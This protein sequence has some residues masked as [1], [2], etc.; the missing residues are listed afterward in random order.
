VSADAVLA[1]GKGASDILVH[2]KAH[3]D[4]SIA[5]DSI[6]GA[7]QILME[8][9][10]YSKVRRQ[11][12]REIGSFQAIKHRCADMK[13]WLEAAKALTNAAI[14]RFVAGEY[15][16]PLI[17]SAKVYASQTYREIAMD[18]VQIHGGIG[19]TWEHDCHLFLKRALLNEQLG[20]SAEQYKDSLFEPF[21]ALAE[22]R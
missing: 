12:G 4:L 8:T 22:S 6:G 21:A 13:T 18:A 11:F 10:E 17:G 16:S 5:C 15:G 9:V 2:V 20:G 1:R 7:E 14:R 19:F 3:F